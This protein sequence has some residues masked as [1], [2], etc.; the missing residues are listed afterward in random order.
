MKKI[1][2]LFLILL[3]F[4]ASV[5]A[6]NTKELRPICYGLFSRTL[7]CSD[8]SNPV[9]HTITIR[10]VPVGGAGTNWTT[11]DQSLAVR[12]EDPVANPAAPLF[13]LTWDPG[14]Q[15]YSLS[16]SMYVGNPCNGL[17]ID[18][19]W[20]YLAS[21]FLTGF[22]PPFSLNCD[23]PKLFWF[24]FQSHPQPEYAYMDPDH[25]LE[26]CPPDEGRKASPFILN[27]VAYNNVAL[28]SNPVRDALTFDVTTTQDAKVSVLVL[29][30]M[31]RSV[32]PASAYDVPAGT[33][34]LNAGLPELPAGIYF[35]H[36]RMGSETFF[37]KVS[38][39]R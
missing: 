21:I 29:D 32:R 38:V 34:V 18:M 19:N 6:T 17:A 36:I 1:I 8:G 11:A 30:G 3:G 20:P 28:R 16:V 33:S 23:Q 5:Q 39:V 13:D 35:V 2:P 12:F 14:T 24:S 4:A 37:H 25:R 22:Q 10:F 15:T 7:L 27:T 26:C 9:N 31:G